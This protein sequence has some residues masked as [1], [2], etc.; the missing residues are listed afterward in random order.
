MVASIGVPY[1]ASNGRGWL[2]QWAKSS[3]AMQA[4]GHAAEYN[5]SGHAA[6]DLAGSQTQFSI[7][8]SI[9]KGSGALLYPTTIPLEGVRAMQLADVLRMDITKEWVYRQWAR[10]STSLADLQYF[11]VRVPLVT[12]TDLKDLAGSLTYFFGADGQCARI[13]FRGRT[14]DTSELVALATQRYNL[15]RQPTLIPGEQLYQLRREKDVI[16]QMRTRPAPVLWS[17]SPHSSFTVE[18]DLQRPDSTI[19]LPPEPRKVAQQKLAQQPQTVESDPSPSQDTP[20]KP[21]EPSR[22]WNALFPRSQVPPGQ[23]ENLDKLGRGW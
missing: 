15:R 13:S 19:P 8:N 1:V 9:P 21:T 4:D 3:D 2:D 7:L 5:E 22:P 16:S 11:S 10:K 6:V 18:L 23:I 17:S 12:G 14:G 20:S